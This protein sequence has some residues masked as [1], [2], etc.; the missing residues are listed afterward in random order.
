MM[1]TWVFAA[2]IAPGLL[3]A[4]QLNLRWAEIPGSIVTGRKVA[5]HLRDEAVLRGKALS[6]AP[7]GLQMAISNAPKG[8]V[9]YGKGEFLIPAGEV[10]TLKVNRTGKRGRIIGSAIGGGLG[11]V[12]WGFWGNHGLS[13]GSGWAL[14]AGAICTVP[15]GVG[16]LVGRAMDLKTTTIQVIAEP[17]PR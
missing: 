13:A 5:V 10:A 2:V 12:A 16:Y 7:G 9:K 11:A 4:E 8:A 3:C 14:I 17:N 1:R 15:L 6:V